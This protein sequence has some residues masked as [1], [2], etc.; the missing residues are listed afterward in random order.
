MPYWTQQDDKV[1]ITEIGK[2][3][4]Q[5]VCPNHANPVIWQLAIKYCLQ[6]DA[7]ARPPFAD[8]M[9]ELRRVYM[10]AQMADIYIEQAQRDAQAEGQRA[11]P[12]GGSQ[13]IG[14]GQE[15]SSWRPQ[16][17]M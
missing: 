4:Q 9:K 14:G 15:G 1:L 17:G 10:K 7:A 5:L 2:G 13:D 11:Q 8:L 6:R 3:T 16:R 12:A